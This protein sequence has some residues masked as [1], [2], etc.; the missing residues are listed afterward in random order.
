MRL[1]LYTLGLLSALIAP[2]LQ[3]TAKGPQNPLQEPAPVNFVQSILTN[4]EAKDYCN[5][6]LHTLGSSSRSNCKY[7]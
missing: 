2:S 1:T 6:S 5:V 3:Q 7:F 4:N